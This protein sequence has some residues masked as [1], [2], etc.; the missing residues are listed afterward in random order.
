[1]ARGGVL[2]TSLQPGVAEHCIA[3]SPGLKESGLFYFFFKRFLIGHFVQY[4]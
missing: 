4:A 1:M 3:E 2:A